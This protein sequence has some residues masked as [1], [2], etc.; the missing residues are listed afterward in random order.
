MPKTIKNQYYKKINYEKLMEA[1]NKSKK[2][3]GLR[4]K[5]YYLT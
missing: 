4:R 1:H 5:L 3:K 2:G